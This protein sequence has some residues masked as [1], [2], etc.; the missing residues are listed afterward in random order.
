M[1]MFSRISD[2]VQANI[3]AM[4]DKAEDPE[5]VIRLITQE[6]EETLVEVRSQAASYIAEKK[7]LDRKIAHLNKLATQWHAKAELAVEKDRDELAKAAL[8]ERQE[9][10]AKT[11]ELQ[12]QKAQ[13]DDV[14][15]KIQSDTA[16]LQTKLA[17][18]NLKQKSLVSRKNTSAI[19]LK[20]RQVE[21]SEKINH[22][23]NRF[24]QYEQR[25][26]YL[27]AQ[28]DAFDVV[29]R[30]PSA[31]ALTEQ[32]AALEKNDEVERELAEL[33]KRSAA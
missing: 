24:E 1:G 30:A 22:A 15:A 8:T 32:F 17:E 33:K 13:I 23:M 11:A 18:A 26:E 6:M 31:T 19:Q 14:L 25:I 27:E 21:H 20:V 16:K 10:L 28:V 5:K 4:L 2:I 12:E 7:Q 3:N 9:C 29:S